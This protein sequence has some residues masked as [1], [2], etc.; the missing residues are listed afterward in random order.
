MCRLNGPALVARRAKQTLAELARPRFPGTPGERECARNL[1]Q[2][3]EAA[4]YLVR[5]EEFYCGEFY[6]GGFSCGRADVAVRRLFGLVAVGALAAAW[7]L[8]ATLPLASAAIAASLLAAAL[9]VGRVWL[10]ITSRLASRLAARLTPR[11]PGRSRNLIA[12]RPGASPRLY[13]SAHYDSKSQSVPLVLRLALMLILAAA[14]LAL[15]GLLAAR[16][17]GASVAPDATTG[18]LFA[19]AAALSLVLVWQGEGN[20]SPGALDNGAAVALLAELARAVD[21]PD[22]GFIFFGAEELGLLGSLDFARRR[23]PPQPFG[24]VNL[25][26]IG[27][28]GRLRLFGQG[29]LGAALSRAAREAQVALRPSPLWPGLLMDHVALARSGIAAVSLGCVGGPSGAIHSAADRPELVE[30]EGLREAAALL[31]A[32]TQGPEAPVTR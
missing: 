31:L 10:A 6:C 1:A 3:L 20:E 14:L 32:L 4:G 29:E 7:A 18:A 22:I 24:V 27:L 25:D 13:L 9:L 28:A 19:L 11:G 21:S 12:A 8:S 2:R 23:P 16:A 17:A 26:G 30:E 15:T 5:E